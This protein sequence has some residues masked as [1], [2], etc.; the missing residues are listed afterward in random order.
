MIGLHPIEPDT[1]SEELLRLEAIYTEAFPPEERRDWQEML[2]LHASEAPMQLYRITDTRSQRSLGLLSIWFLA[3]GLFGEYL[4]ID[5]S[6][7][8]RGWGR[9]VIRRLKNNARKWPLI[10]EAE[11]PQT[12]MAAR[13]LAFYAREGLHPILQEY[14]Q[15]DYRRTGQPTPMYL[16]SSNPRPASALLRWV[17]T[18][19]RTVY[20]GYPTPPLPSFYDPLPLG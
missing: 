6:L 12:P 2:S 14:L 17:E 11:P 13:R 7:R 8:N 15:P 18:I 1:P 19:Y 16:L 4:A 3:E 9:E 5:T 10:V 20:S